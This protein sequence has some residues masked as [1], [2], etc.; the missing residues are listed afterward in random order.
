MPRWSAPG[1]EVSA[2]SPADCQEGT[3]S[4]PTVLTCDESALLRVDLA[5]QPKGFMQNPL[6]LMPSPPFP[7]TPDSGFAKIVATALGQKRRLRRAPG[8]EAT[9]PAAAGPRDSSQPLGSCMPA[10]LQA[11]ELALPWAPWP[12]TVLCHRRPVPGPVPGMVGRPEAWGQ[13]GAAPWGTP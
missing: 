12:G 3:G 13:R 9:S 4:H 1:H 7:K 11:A 10:S 8:A 6:F 5:L 2:I